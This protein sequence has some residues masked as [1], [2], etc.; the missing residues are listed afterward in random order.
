MPHSGVTLWD[1]C[2]G[3]SLYDEMVPYSRIGREVGGSGS[4]VQH[5]AH[6]HWPP[7]DET[8]VKKRR[9]SGGP[10]RK[11]WTP[12]RAKRLLR[13]ASTLPPLASDRR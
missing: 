6:D 2:L 8:E 12:P 10:P 7:R 13:G 1:Q 4:A 5:F 9:L 11:P 3:R